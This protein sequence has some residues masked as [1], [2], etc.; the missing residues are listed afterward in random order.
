MNSMF[1]CELPLLPGNYGIALLDDGNMDGDMNYNF[2][3]MPK[4]G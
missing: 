2:I 1:R 4:E 3:V